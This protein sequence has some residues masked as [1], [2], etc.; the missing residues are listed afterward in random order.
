[1]IKKFSIDDI[2]TITCEATNIAGKAETSA[3]LSMTKSPPSFL[4]SLPRSEEIDEGEPLELKAKVDGSPIPAVK[5]FKNGEEIKPSQHIKIEALP[6]GTVKLTI[7]TVKPTDC[8]AYKCIAYN[9]NGE[10]SGLCAV[11]V[12]REYPTTKLPLQHH[13]MI[14]CNE[15]LITQLNR[16]DQASSRV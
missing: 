3:K 8:G 5:W 12:K 10:S 16:G 2:A 9:P 14:R 7:D 15:T 4:R 6:D 13:F 11:A 1:M